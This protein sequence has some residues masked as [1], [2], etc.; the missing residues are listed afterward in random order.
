MHTRVGHVVLQ[1]QLVLGI[2]IHMIN[3]RITITIKIGVAARLKWLAA[4]L[5]ESDCGNKI[6]G[7]WDDGAIWIL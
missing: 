3:L 4:N 5:C 7:C 2:R 1:D 6:R